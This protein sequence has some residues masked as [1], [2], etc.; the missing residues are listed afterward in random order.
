M[1]DELVE[2]V[3]HRAVR[4]VWGVAEV[5]LLFRFG[6]VGTEAFPTMRAAYAVRT[7]FISASR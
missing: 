5:A 4:R 2:A 1:R 6:K 3:R 7:F